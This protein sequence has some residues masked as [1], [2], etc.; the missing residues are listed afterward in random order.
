MKSLAAITLLLFTAYSKVNADSNIYGPGGVNLGPDGDLPIARQQPLDSSENEEYRE[1]IKEL[2]E[3]VRQLQSEVRLL[4]Q[5]QQLQSNLQGY[6]Q[7]QYQVEINYGYP[8]Q[9]VGN[10]LWGVPFI[11]TGV[12]GGG[13]NR[14]PHDDGEHDHGNRQESNRNGRGMR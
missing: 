10:R 8:T 12:G 5:V 9:N 1:Q 14:K 4:Q 11:T 2:Q 13:V 6:P 3:Q 7:N